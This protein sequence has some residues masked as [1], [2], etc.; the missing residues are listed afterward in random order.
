MLLTDN[1]Y[2]SATV[3]VTLG[4][5]PVLILSE[6]NGYKSPLLL[7]NRTNR[8]VWSWYV[9]SGFEGTYTVVYFV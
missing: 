3:F 8:G 2:Q 1:V 4:G 6:I 7:A 9:V 5:E